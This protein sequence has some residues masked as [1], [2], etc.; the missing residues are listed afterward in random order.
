[1]SHSPVDVAKRVLE[2]NEVDDYVG[3]LNLAAPSVDA[4]IDRKSSVNQMRKYYL[5][6][7]LTIHPDRMGKTFPEAT[8][9]FQALVKAF[10]HLTSPE[11]IEEV[12]TK[13]GKKGKEKTAAIS[14][15][16]DGCYRTRVCC[17]RCKQPWNEGTLDGNPDYC[18]NF[19]MTGLKSYTC[20][21]CLCEFG[22]MTALHKCPFCKKGFEYSP[23]DY[24][25]KI[26]CG[27]SS[28][29]KPFGFMMYHASDR[30]IKDLKQ[31]VKEEQERQLRAREA[32][33]RRAKR[34]GG[35][36]DQTT[37]EKAFMMGLSDVCPRCGED[38]VEMGDEDEQ[39]RHLA[40]CTDE[41]KHKE[42]ATK[43][44]KKAATKNAQEA[45]QEAQAAAQ[46][47]AAW[48][49][50]GASKSQLWLLNEEQLR[51]QAGSLNLDISGDKDELICRIVSQD[52][53]T[54]GNSGG[55]ARIKNAP[56]SSAGKRKRS[57]EATS[58]TSSALVLSTTQSASSSSSG[59][60]SKALVR[61]QKSAQSASDALPS[62]YHSYSAAQ[63]RSMCAAQGLLGLLPKKAVK[64]DMIKVLEKTVFEISDDDD[65]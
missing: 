53:S 27:H 60:G 23:L 35:D 59:A 19:L 26:T 51:A 56:T 32:K 44:A 65:E 15:S 40:E 63:L 64:A 17:P 28:C 9:A 45:R 58:N 55:T 33:L 10:E 21:T 54:V 52:T 47:H 39:R 8:K 20:S 31:S 34:G 42:H 14:R 7:S 1:M 4:R 13:G 36:V 24:H 38:F 50:M 48:Q 49:L 2:L 61:A 3:I 37:A 5:K 12:E 18:Y 29:K 41:G 6:L 22:C 30:V 43:V 16:N 25:N 46:T 11:L 62:N 57:E